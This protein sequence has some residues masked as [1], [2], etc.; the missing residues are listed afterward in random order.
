MTA[1]ALK[2]GK[3]PPTKDSRDLRLADY[4]TARKVK[5]APKGF[6]HEALVPSWGM[7]LNDQLGDCEI[8]RQ[9]HSVMLWNACAGRQVTFTDEEAER[10]YSAVTGYD[11]RDPASDQG[12]VMRDCL[13]YAQKNGVVDADGVT[14]RIGAYLA[15]DAKDTALL[16][17]ALY[18]C[19]QVAIGFEVPQ[20][21]MSQFYYGRPWTVVRGSPRI[22][23]HAIEVVGR[24][25]AEGL[26][27][28][29]WGQ[30]QR[31]TFGFYRV[32]N[33][34]AWAVISPEALN[35]GRTLEGFDVA[36]LQEDLA[37]L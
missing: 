7:L 10:V 34:E 28:V 20:S 33:D 1:P 15:I 3:L 27:A 30:L 35:G 19:D 29:T 21:A 6:G 13:K 17:H 12:T 9:L 2:L 4:L 18:L 16:L 14:H 32:Y 31:L 11:P 23:G 37:A 5:A 8:A 25:A 26:E 24:P 22:G 36:A